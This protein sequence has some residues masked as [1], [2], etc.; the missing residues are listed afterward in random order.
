MCISNMADFEEAEKDSVSPVNSPQ[1]S[2]N[3]SNW[4]PVSDWDDSDGVS[5][6]LNSAGTGKK[7]KR[8]EMSMGF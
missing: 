6:T 7:R 3:D 2:T 5:E 8:E 1:H 4:K